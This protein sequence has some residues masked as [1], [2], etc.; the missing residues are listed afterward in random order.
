MS[1]QQG[2]VGRVNVEDIEKRKLLYEIE[3]ELWSLLKR[4]AWIIALL[5]LGG[6]WIAV[7]YT[8]QQVAE[9]PL[10][11]LEKQLVRAEV[12]AEEAKRANTAATSAA[13]QVAASVSTLQATIQSLNGQAK[14]VEDQFKLVKEQI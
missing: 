13:E 12:Q 1:D 14:A 9:G 4:R 11:E 3:D 5:G 6:I 8:V 2:S 10:K 7:H